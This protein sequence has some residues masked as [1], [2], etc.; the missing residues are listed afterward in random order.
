[1]VFGFFKRRRRRNLRAQPTP[2]E[3]RSTLTRNVPFFR[4]L[5]PADQDELLGHVRVFLAEK[6]FEGCGGLELTD[7]IRLTIAAQ[8]CLLLL[9]RE[10]DYYPQLSS[11][12][13]YP[14]SYNVPGERHL[15]GPIWEEGEQTFLGHA[16]NRLGSIVLAWDAAKQGGANSFDGQNVVLHEFAHQL[17]FENYT[18]DGAPALASRAEYASWA[19]VMMREYKALQ[20]AE[21]AGASTVLDTYGATDPA[22]FFAVATE[23]FFERPRALR[24]RHPELYAALG[25]YF[26]QD[27]ARHF[28]ES[29]TT[30]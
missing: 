12:L 25:Q 13:V 15:E 5:P 6:R 10:T 28:A 18:T 30:D 29:V 4:R 1:M 19:E 3:W 26:C 9:H 21:E 2:P 23:A 11:I 7:E 24:A 17:D 16:T 8:A 22:E 20:A 14:S 27:P